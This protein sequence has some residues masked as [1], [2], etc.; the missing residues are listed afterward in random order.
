MTRLIELGIEMLLLVDKRI[1]LNVRQHVHLTPVIF[2]FDKSL[3]L[4]LY[5]LLFYTYTWT[6]FIC[7]LL[8]AQL[9]RDV[10]ITRH[11]TKSRGGSFEL[12]LLI[13]NLLR[14]LRE[15][16]L[17][18]RIDCDHVFHCVFFGWLIH[19]LVICSAQILDE[20]SVHF[21]SNFWVLVL[22]KYRLFDCILCLC[23][24]LR[25]LGK[26]LGAVIIIAVH[27]RSHI[28]VSAEVCI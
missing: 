17:I 22:R 27:F 1:C 9:R 11:I 2:T 16:F 8:K 28:H 15:H 26:V 10:L 12:S 13:L 23:I 19:L 5:C 14:L 20:T 24:Q 18:C 21:R 4:P 3:L 7:T 25:C 6:L